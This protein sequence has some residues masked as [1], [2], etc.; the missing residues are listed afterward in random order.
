V[1]SLVSSL[2]GCNLNDSEPQKSKPRFNTTNTFLLSVVV[3]CC[4][5][6][7]VVVCCCCLLSV[8][9]CLLSVVCCLLS[10]VLCCL[11][12]STPLTAVGARRDRKSVANVMAM[13]VDGARWC[14]AMFGHLG[15]VMR[16]PRT[17]AR[18]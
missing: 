10:V 11:F 13:C 3:C 4:L 9:C 17:V 1:E 5:L 12:R 8:V 16:S 2:S 6:L 18:V 7:S 14:S 15:Y